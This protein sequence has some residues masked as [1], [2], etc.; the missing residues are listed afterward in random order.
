MLAG[1]HRMFSVG[2][3]PQGSKWKQQR[4][5]PLQKSMGRPVAGP[6]RP[7]IFHFRFKTFRPECAQKEDN[8][9]AQDIHANYHPKDL[10]NDPPGKASN[11]SHAFRYLLSK[12]RPPRIRREVSLFDDG[13]CGCSAWAFDPAWMECPVLLDL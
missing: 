12:A 8:V 9:A 13:S 2:D 3:S 1:F 5:A 7:A 6:R 4:K 10:P 11:V